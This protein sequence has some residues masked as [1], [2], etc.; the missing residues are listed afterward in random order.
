[1][2]PKGAHNIFSFIVNYHKSRI[3]FAFFLPSLNAAARGGDFFPSLFVRN[4][5]QNVRRWGRAHSDSV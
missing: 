3:L 1:M 2:W 4:K 5:T